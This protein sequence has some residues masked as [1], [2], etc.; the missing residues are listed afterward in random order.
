MISPFKPQGLGLTRTLLF[1]LSMAFASCDDDSENGPRPREPHFDFKNECQNIG[2][3]VGRFSSFMVEV[4]GTQYDRPMFNPHDADELLYHEWGDGFSRIIKYRISTREK[5][6]FLDPAPLTVELDWG[7]GGWVAFSGYGDMFLIRE[8]GTDL[9]RVPLTT[10]GHSCAEPDFNPDGTV[11]GFPFG[12][13]NGISLY[14]MYLL[15]DLNKN[16]LDTFDHF[17]GTRPLGW[18]S[19][20]EMSL[21]TGESYDLNGKLGLTLIHMKD[22]NRTLIFQYSDMKWLDNSYGSAD[23]MWNHSGENLYY[24]DGDII[25]FPTNDYKEIRIK[26][27]CESRYYEDITIAPDDKHI[28]VER[29][30]VRRDGPY[31]NTLQRWRRLYIMDIDGCNERLLFDD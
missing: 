10:E 23:M 12:G 13:V 15:Y 4:M 8:D 29:V 27:G 17:N 31:S 24:T 3:P 22:Y 14:G 5:E 16:D 30:D 9:H 11:V 26:K 18:S 7:R 20:N 28:I 21:W 19:N 2:P 25:C 6:V 1:A